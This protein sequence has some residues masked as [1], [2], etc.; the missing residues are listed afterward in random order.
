MKARLAYNLLLCTLF[1]SFLTTTTAHAQDE[2]TC[3]NNTTQADRLR[4]EGSF[5]EAVELLQSCKDS[6][7]INDQQRSRIYEILA[8]SY[9]GLRFENDAREAIRNLLRIA[10]DYK[11]NEQDDKPLYKQWVRE[12][13]QEMGLDEPEEVI[14]EPEPI[15]AAQKSKRR[16]ALFIGGGAV[17]AGGIIYAIVCCDEK[18]NPP[19]PAPAYPGGN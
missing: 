16:R 5:E 8:K 12:I 6:S 9:E 2:A 3:V 10:P 19:L 4:L 17:V 14:A 1:F 11:V 18:G 13:K 15:T 7:V